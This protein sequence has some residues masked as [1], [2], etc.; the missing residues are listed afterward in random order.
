MIRP[1]KVGLAVK[2]KE[3]AAVSQD[4][5]GI[6]AELQ[7]G[8]IDQRLEGG[9]HGPLSMNRPIEE[10]VFRPSG[11]ALDRPVFQDNGTALDLRKFFKGKQNR[12]I[13]RGRSDA[14]PNPVTCLQLL[15]EL[16]LVAGGR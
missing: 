8:G 4:I 12:V 1:R 16:F 10:P 5:C 3:I 15:Q 14:Y 11:H 9:P 7:S 6:P 2:N 13:L